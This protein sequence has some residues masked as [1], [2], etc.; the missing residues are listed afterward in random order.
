MRHAGLVAVL[1]IAWCSSTAA[2]DGSTLDRERT[3]RTLIESECRTWAQRQV[4][5]EYAPELQ[6][7]ARLQWNSALMGSR[8]FDGVSVSDGARPRVGVVR[9]V[10]GRAAPRGLQG[11]DGAES[12]DGRRVLQRRAD[13]GAPGPPERPGGGVEPAHHRLPRRRAD[14]QDGDRKSTRLNSSH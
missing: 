3:S 1:V 7:A 12:A 13:R 8:T 11:A 2:R 10:Q 4:R 14:A 9:R 5:A 6:D